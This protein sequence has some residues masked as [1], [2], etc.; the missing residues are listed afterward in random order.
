MISIAKQKLHFGTIPMQSSISSIVT[1]VVLT[2]LMQVC[3]DE[4]D[5]S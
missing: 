5:A 1:F 3:G 2:N 4:R